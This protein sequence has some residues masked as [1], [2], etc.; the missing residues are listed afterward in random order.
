MALTTADLNAIRAAA[1]EQLHRAGI[2][3]R[4]GEQDRMDIADFQLGRFHEVGLVELVYVNTDRY[5]AKELVLLPYQTCP[6][7]W[8]PPVGSDPGKQESFRCRAGEVFLYVEGESTP[9]PTCRPPEG[10][11]A[12]Y[13]VWHELNLRPGDQ[14]C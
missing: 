5:A 2:A 1:A 7:H 14:V 10:D 4:D 11:A 9:Q 8:H 13:T 3:L 12:Y 6:E